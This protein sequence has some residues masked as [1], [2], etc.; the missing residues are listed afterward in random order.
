MPARAQARRAAG[1]PFSK[2]RAQQRLTVDVASLRISS[3]GAGGNSRTSAADGERL[4]RP[5]SGFASKQAAEKQLKLQQQREEQERQ[6]RMDSVSNAG[7]QAVMPPVEGEWKTVVSHGRRGRQQLDR[8]AASFIV[9]SSGSSR[10]PPPPPPQLKFSA[11]YDSAMASSKEQSRR[12]NQRRKQPP[13]SPSSPAAGFPSGEPGGVPPPSFLGQVMFARRSSLQRLADELHVEQASQKHSSRPRKNSPDTERTG[14]GLVDSAGTPRASQQHQRSH[15]RRSRHSELADVP[16]EA[17]GVASPTSHRS[18]GADEAPVERKKCGDKRDFFFR[19]LDFEIR[20]QLQ[21]DQVAEFSVTDYEMA[22]KIS[23]VVLKL[24]GYGADDYRSCDAAEETGDCD[25]DGV[26]CTRKN[27]AS[28]TGSVGTTEK[29][30]I[31][32]T[33][34]TACV[35]GNVLSF[36]DYF[37]HVNAVECDATRL[38]MLRHNLTVLHKDNATC[39]HASYL[40]VML[41]L[42]QDVVFLDPPWGG[43][44][45]KELTKVDLY[46]D[47]IPLHDICSR[48]QGHAE[49]VVLKVPSNFDCDKFA[50]HVPGSVAVHRDLKKMHLVVLDFR[51]VGAVE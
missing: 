3:A 37:A 10:G 27:S 40:D 23:K 50:Q 13:P 2:D 49:C 21:V 35:G 36:C 16:G 9:S 6:R 18:S 15:Q 46:L 28:S 30:P 17:S 38:Q 22:A 1:S 44:E 20:N 39:I 34:G 7:V 11:S 47:G 41:A 26:V 51:D 8:R 25:Q 42:T 31:V 5:A 14:S 45:Y 4:M 24:F 32:V 33:D 43:P 19:N 12:K 29:C 48:L